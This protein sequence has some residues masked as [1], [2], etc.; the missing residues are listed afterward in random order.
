MSHHTTATSPIASSD[1][2][3]IHVEYDL[4]HPPAKVWR[5][6]TEPALVAAWLMP[7]D[8]EAK[9]GHAFTFQ[10]PPMPGWDG[11]VECE[12]LAVE[13]ERLLRYS[14]RGGAPGSRLDSVVTWTLSPT[15]DGGTRLSLEHSGFL[16]INRFAFEA[17]SQGWSEKL[18]PRMREVLAGL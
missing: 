5:A 6:I 7:N 8:L 18:G 2:K 17:M 13:P 11:V 16:P 4:A 10:A 9:V 1:S 3:T 14:W 12:V 15:G